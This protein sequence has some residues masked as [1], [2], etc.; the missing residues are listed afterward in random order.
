MLH[1]EL[2][3][4]EA[5]GGGGEGFWEMVPLQVGGDCTKTRLTRRKRGLAST[6]AWHTPRHSCSGSR[7]SCVAGDRLPRRHL[8]A[9]PARRLASGGPVQG[10]PAAV[11]RAVLVTSARDGHEHLAR[12][13]RPSVRCVCSLI[14]A[15]CLLSR[16]RWL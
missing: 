4:L 10:G 16:G 15:A 13:D 6:H 3:G 7:A 5:G 8:F 9:C 11:W 12:V 14:G 2:L 1:R